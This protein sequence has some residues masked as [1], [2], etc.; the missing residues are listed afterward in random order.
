MSP[1][2]NV[3]A[4]KLRYNANMTGRG[5]GP[6]TN[7]GKKAEICNCGYKIRGENHEKGIHHVSTRKSKKR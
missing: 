3:G 7:K 2:G 6:E 5:H 1:N 4:K